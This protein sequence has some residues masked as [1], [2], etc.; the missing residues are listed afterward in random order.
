MPGRGRAC[1]PVPRCPRPRATADFGGPLL[2]SLRTPA[3]RGAVGGKSL[4]A[5]AP[6][7]GGYVLSTAHHADVVIIGAGTAGLAA[8]HQLTSAGVSVSVLEAGPR[9]GGRMITDDVDG[10]RLDRL[11]PLLTTAYPELR[12]AP[13][14]EGLLT[15]TFA[16]GVLVHSE[17]RQY[18]AGD[19]RSARGALKAA[20]AGAGAPRPPASWPGPSAPRSPHC[21]TGAC[22]PVRSTASCAPCSRRCSA[23]L[24]SAPP[25][26]APISPC[27][28][29]RA[30]GSASRP[31]AHRRCPNCWPPRCRP[32]RC[33]PGC[34][35]RPPTSPRCARRST[36]R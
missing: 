29:T 31:G 17:G 11:G 30:A 5:V 32:G 7:R 35:S 8:A 18:R 19:T 27:A 15:R 1:D 26:G 16:P 24:N 2:A 23:I 28:A 13:G 14:L 36:A 21:R 34:T 4:P 22:P 6:T 10:F 9:V 3:F 25:A 12:L 33:A 20:R